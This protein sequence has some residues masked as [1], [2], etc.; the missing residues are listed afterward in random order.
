VIALEPMPVTFELLAAT[1]RRAPAAN[2]TL[3]NLAAS[4]GAARVRMTPPTWQAGRDNLSM[5]RV[6]PAVDAARLQ[7]PD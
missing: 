3:L 6:A 5:A 4:D 2:Q 1:A 7:I